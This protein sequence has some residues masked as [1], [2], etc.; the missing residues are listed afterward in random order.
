MSD[1][2]PLCEFSLPVER[3]DHSRS[4]HIRHGCLGSIESLDSGDVSRWFWFI[5]LLLHTHHVV[6][7]DLPKVPT[8][9][10][11]VIFDNVHLRQR[12]SPG[13]DGPLRGSL[14]G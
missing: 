2:A 7:V 11:L 5:M 3:S 13:Y 8:V 4:C 1:D 14:Y 9:L 6:L 12:P 10:E